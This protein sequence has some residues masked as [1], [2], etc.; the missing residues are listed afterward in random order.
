[1][2]K[3]IK[4]NSDKWNAA[5]KWCQELREKKNRDIEFIIITEKNIETIFG[6]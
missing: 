6:G 3:S 2:K 1:M 5:K 4:T